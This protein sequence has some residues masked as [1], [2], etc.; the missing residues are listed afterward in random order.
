[1]FEVDLAGL[2]L[3]IVQQFLDQREQR[4]AGGFHRPRVGRLFRRQRRIQQQAAHA[5]DAVQR[6]AN[7]M[8]GHGEEPRLGAVGGV[9]LV[10]RLAEHALGLGAVG[11][12]AADALHFRRAAGIRP[13][14]TFAPGDPSRPQGTCDLLVVHPGAVG[15]QHA[16]A[17]LQHLEGEFAADQSF[18]RQ[19]RQIAI[20][21]V[22]EGDAALGVAHHDQVALRFEQAAGALLRLPAIPNC[23]RP[24]PRCAGRSCASS[25]AAGAAACLKWRARSRRARTGSSRRSQSRA[26]RNPIVPTG[27]R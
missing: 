12:V 17:L 10:A 16:D 2:D 8:G 15:L 27:C 11:D 24:A 23:G 13:D 20:G 22:D 18:A 25:C 26:G 3:G 21:V 5:D 6:I 9:G 19:Q 7:L 14:K 4:V 1:M